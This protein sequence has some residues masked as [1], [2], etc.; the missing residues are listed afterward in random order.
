[1]NTGDFPATQLT[2]RD[3]FAAAALAGTSKM[4]RGLPH[5]VAEEAYAI[6]DEM[7]KERGAPRITDAMLKEPQL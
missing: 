2:L 1:M 4:V 6:A 5:R 3:Y 7:L